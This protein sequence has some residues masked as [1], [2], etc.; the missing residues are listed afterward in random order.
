MVFLVHL[1]PLRA[2]VFWWYSLM[3]SAANERSSGSG[4]FLIFVPEIP[5]CSCTGMFPCAKVPSRASCCGSRAGSLWSRPSRSGGPVAVV[6]LLMVVFDWAVLVLAVL[7]P[8]HFLFNPSWVFCCKAT[9][10]AASVLSWSNSILDIMRSSALF[11]A[12]CL[13]IWNFR[14]NNCKRMA[15]SP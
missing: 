5:E 11:S 14:C 6:D 3:K 7:D 4:F 2:C 9:S 15:T 8:A 10:L 12:V 1:S 13:R